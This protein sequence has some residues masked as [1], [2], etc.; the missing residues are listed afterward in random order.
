MR[1]GNFIAL[2]EERPSTTIG[3]YASLGSFGEQ[4]LWNYE[5]SFHR[6]NSGADIGLNW[7]LSDPQSIGRP[8]VRVRQFITGWSWADLSPFA[9]TLQLGSLLTG[10]RLVL[11]YGLF[12]TVETGIPLCNP[13]F[14]E[15][16]FYGPWVNLL[17]HIE[18]PFSLESGFYLNGQ[19]LASLTAPGAV[20]EPSTWVLLGVGLAG[21]AVRMRRASR[22]PLRDGRCSARACEAL[23]R[24]GLAR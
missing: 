5:A 6:S 11:N 3:A 12:A 10:E 1:L 19:S 8:A 7:Q 15:D 9:G 14:C 24:E 17:A 18:D 20:P 2:G 4:S 16:F 21:M 22:T 13:E 23:R